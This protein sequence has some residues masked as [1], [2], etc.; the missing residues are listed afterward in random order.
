MLVAC[1][2]RSLAVLL[3]VYSAT[4]G[5]SH[6]IAVALAGRSTLPRARV[7]AVNLWAD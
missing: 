5:A 1:T 3:L 7:L 4:G 2:G 6:R